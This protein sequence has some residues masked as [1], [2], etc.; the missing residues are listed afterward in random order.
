[1][2]LLDVRRSASLAGKTVVICEDEGVTVLHLLK[3]LSA[4]GMAVVGCAV[5]GAEAVK[6]ALERRP[7][8]ILMDINMPEMDGIEAARRILDVYRPCIV[9]LTAYAEEKYLDRA[10]SAGVSGYIVKPVYGAELL[11]LIGNALSNSITAQAAVHA[12]SASR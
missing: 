11:D 3:A 8:V 9:M 10:L 2:T 4:A 12:A 7:D 6:V 5:N 1:M